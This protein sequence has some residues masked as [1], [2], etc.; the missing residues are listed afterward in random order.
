MTRAS[1]LLDKMRAN[2]RDDWTI[3]Q[4]GTVC[5]MY[6]DEL[7]LRP[8]S[9]RGSHF[10]LIHPGGVLTIPARRPIKPVYVKRV[11]D[12]IDGITVPKD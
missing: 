10:T 8:P 6:E 7:T 12:I 11:V 1:K 4:I 5:R 3:E 9:R 2:P